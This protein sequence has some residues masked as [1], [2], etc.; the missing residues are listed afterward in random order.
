MRDLPV[1][2]SSW[3]WG[4]LLF[5][6]FLLPASHLLNY[7]KRPGP[8]WICW[9]VFMLV[10]SLFLAVLAPWWVGGALLLPSGLLCGIVYLAL[11]K[12]PKKKDPPEDISHEERL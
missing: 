10:S 4:A 2:I 7:K 8:F 9:G 11:R 1:V 6:F 12:A 5:L 3:Q